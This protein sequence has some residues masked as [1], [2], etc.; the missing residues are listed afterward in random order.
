LWA[1]PNASVANDGEDLESWLARRERVR[2]TAANGNGF[3]MQLTQQVKMESWPTPRVT[4]SGME[5]SQAQ[6]RRVLNGEQSERGAGACKLELTV[7]LEAARSTAGPPDPESGSTDGKHQEFP[8]PTANRWDGLQS[9][10][11]NV[12]A[13]RLNPEW[14]AQL[15]GYPDG[16]LDIE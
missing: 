9:H 3:G 2:Q 8:T 11:V 15:M 10:G 4:T 14:V 5:A 13:G 1:T 7:A 12:V 16:W 6:V